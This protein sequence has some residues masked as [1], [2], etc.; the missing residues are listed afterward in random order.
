MARI[1]PQ[2][3]AALDT[4]DRLFFNQTLF[5][6]LLEEEK[7]GPGD[8]KREAELVALVSIVKRVGEEVARIGARGVEAE[9]LKHLVFCLL[10]VTFS[11]SLV[12]ATQDGRPRTFTLTNSEGRPLSELAEK[13]DPKAAARLHEYQQNFFAAT[14]AAMG[15]VAHGTKR[16]DAMK[17]AM[18]LRT[19]FQDVPTIVRYRLVDRAFAAEFLDAPVK[20]LCW[21]FEIDVLNSSKFVASDVKRSISDEL[22]ARI[23]LLCEFSLLRNTMARHF[24]QGTLR[25]DSIN[26]LQDSVWDRISETANL[27]M[28]D[29]NAFYVRLDHQK[30]LRLSSVVFDL[31]RMG[32][33]DYLHQFLEKVANLQQRSRFWTGGQHSWCGVIGAGMIWAYRTLVDSEKK[34]TQN[35]NDYTRSGT[36][37]AKKETVAEDMCRVLREHGFTHTPGSLYETL[38]NYYLKEPDG[39][40]PRAQLYHRLQQQF[41]VVF[42]AYINDIFYLGGI[43]VT[44]PESTNE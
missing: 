34:I 26:R 25:R 11:E 42:P 23:G 38:K 36:S 8:A 20:F 9:A 30:S 6:L 12:L 18:A 3:R 41:D 43:V 27:Q 19:E 4:L 39:L 33:G 16:E 2:K 10:E 37:S 35:G 31:S 24:N 40:Y 32:D 14:A 21:M 22:K 13:M 1:T 44:S 28:D 5:L 17:I 7:T 29:E 15:E